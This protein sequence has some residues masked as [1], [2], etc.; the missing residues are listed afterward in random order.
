M[1]GG[2]GQ[3]GASA[4]PIIGAKP[5]PRCKVGFRFPRA[6]VIADFTG[7]GLGGHDI[8][9]INQCQIHAQGPFEFGCEVETRG[10]CREAFCAFWCGAWQQRGRQRFGPNGW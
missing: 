7:D 2:S 3:Y 4:D 9:S 1:A 6:D 8:D 10:R 5:E